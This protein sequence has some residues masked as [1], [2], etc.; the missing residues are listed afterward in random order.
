M[1]AGTRETLFQREKKPGHPILRVI[2]LVVVGVS[3]ISCGGGSDSP[4]TL[5]PTVTDPTTGPPTGNILPGPRPV[6]EAQAFVNF[7]SGQVRPLALSAD[8]QKLFAL[9][10]PDNRLEIFS[11]GAILT[12]I[13][14][15]PVGL[16]PVA[17]GEDPNGFVWVVNHLSDSISVVDVASSPPR[18]IQTLWV[19][20]EPR[21]IVFA[22]ANRERAFITTAHRGQNSPVDPALNFSTGRADV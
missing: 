12:P 9:N 1:T 13:A 7:E 6:A 21:D 8:G 11:T 17:V 10:T 20:D 15:V 22:G 3:L 16:E 14:S 2:Y 19:G 5:P 4:G 18:V